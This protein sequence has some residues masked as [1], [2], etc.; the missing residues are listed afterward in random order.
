ML[1]IPAKSYTAMSVS[2]LLGNVYLYTA[3]SCKGDK[4]DADALK[5][6]LAT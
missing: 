3:K 2:W 1:D 5:S 6:G 4:Q